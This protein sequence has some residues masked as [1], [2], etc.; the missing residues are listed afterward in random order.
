MANVKISSLPAGAA[1]ISEAG[2]VPV[3]LSGVTSKVTVE[4]LLAAAAPVKVLGAYGGTIAAGAHDFVNV[5][6]PI[7][8][9]EGDLFS[10]AK[11][12]TAAVA[13]PNVLLLVEYVSPGARV[14]IWNIDDEEV[15]LTEGGFT[16]WVTAR[17][18]IQI[19]E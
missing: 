5:T 19:E 14:R 12:S 7:F 4:D 13:F 11:T 15:V 2:L 16:F 10:V 18:A 8:L 3:V 1:P 6:F 17:R 9:I